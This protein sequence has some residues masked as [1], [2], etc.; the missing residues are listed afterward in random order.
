MRVKGLQLAVDMTLDF[1]AR[2]AATIELVRANADADL[3]VL[4]ELWPNGGF[5]YELWESTAQ[6]LAGPLVAQLRALAAELQ[7]HL[8]AG[9]FIERRPDGGLSNTSV[10]LA[11]DGE[12]LAAYRKIHLFGF[13]DG[14]PKFLTAGDDV[15]VVSTALGRIG[16]ATCYDLRFPELFRA[17]LEGGA[18][19][20]L[21]PAAWPASRVAHWNVLAQARA[22]ENQYVVVAVNAAGD[23][24]GKTM[25][26]RSIVLDARGGV[27]A[28]ADADAAVVDAAIDL[29][30]VRQWREAFPVIPDR[31]LR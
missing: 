30:D 17:L 1:D 11:P 4:P 2:V 9:S 12:V 18:E 13:A 24:G 3:V 7:I 27:L 8:H 19:L 21:V 5:T 6:P 25:G 10:L 22:I 15:V 20:V 16:L 14:E 23:Q 26:G 31:R 29:R 28:E